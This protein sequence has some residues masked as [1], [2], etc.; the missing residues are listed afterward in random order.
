M[1]IVLN[2][3]LDKINSRNSSNEKE[4]TEKDNSNET[5]NSKFKEQGEMRGVWLSTVNNLDWPEVGSY[6]NNK[7]QQELLKEKLD[8]IEDNNMNTVFFQVRPMGDALYESE[9]SPWSKY[10][11]GELGKD[12]GYDP[13]EFAIKEAHKRGIEIQAWFNPFRIDSN[14]EKFNLDNYINE[15]PEGS[16]LK[17]NKDWIVKY[18][19]YSY[20]DIGIP[21]VRQYVI[22]LILEVVDKYNIDG[23]VLDDYFYP[24]DY[25]LPEGEDREGEVANN[26]RESVNNLIRTIYKVIKSTKPSVQFGVS[27]YGVWK[28]KSSDLIGSESNSLESYYD[29]YMDTLTWID[30]HIVDYIAPQIYWSTDNNDIN[31][32]V[33]VSWWNDVVKD[34]GVR[35]YIGQ[36]INDLDIA[37]EIYKQIEINREYE[38]VSGNILFSASD[39]MNDNDNIV[40]QLKEAYNCKAILPTKFNDN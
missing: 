13:L 2:I 22:D 24:Y 27:P 12:P 39:I 14:S 23:V 35:L 1:A 15:L 8:F 40:M 19:K 28:N 17:E 11:T 7:M 9:Y 30:E 36:N 20:L 16:P 33:M 18:D 37:S 26:R 32:E 21:E 4:V 6:N 25:P 10:L 29:L 34:S 38:Y 3:K 5:F 31:Y